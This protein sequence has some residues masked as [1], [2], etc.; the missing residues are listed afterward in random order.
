MRTGRVI[1]ITGAAGGIGS[2]LV[3]RFLDND[4]T[5]IATDTSPQGLEDLAHRSDG[6]KLSTCVADVSRADDCQAVADTA[7]RND[8][9][10][11]VLL[12]VAGFFPTVAF[13]DMTLDQW[14]RVIDVNLTGQFLMIKAVLPLM[15]DLK[16]GRI[17]NFSSAS[18]FEGFD[19]QVH[20]TAAKAGVIG[21]TRSLAMALGG[22]GI[23]VNAV[24]PGLTLTR[25]IRD[26]FPAD[27]VHAQRD[28]RAIR[29]DETADDLV[30]PTFFL[31][32]PDADFL[33][34]QTVNVD[35]GKHK[36]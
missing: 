6:R 11:D 27:M 36:L 1:V 3:Q 4:D 30:G 5:V 31:A 28:V 7:R 34:G 32:S 18:V 12:N 20:Y 23:T 10:I 24:T 26:N 19:Q 17:V 25:P 22:H 8:G 35:G 9:R 16:W 21:M 2:A 14:R 29:R 33:S 15:K 13:E